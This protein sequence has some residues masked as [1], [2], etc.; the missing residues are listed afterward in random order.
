MDFLD[1]LLFLAVAIPF[2]SLFVDRD[3]ITS[4]HK[5]TPVCPTLL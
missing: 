1:G 5:Y 2:G 3:R 4:F